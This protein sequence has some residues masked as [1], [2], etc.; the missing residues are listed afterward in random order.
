MLRNTNVCNGDPSKFHPLHIRELTASQEI[1]AESRQPN[2]PSSLVAKARN[3]NRATAGG[4]RESI[5][6]NAR[7]CPS[8]LGCSFLLHGI[9][10]LPEEQ[11]P[12]ARTEGGVCK[13]QTPIA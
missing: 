2:R 7:S 5:S 11:D 10:H 8:L 4:A 9:L 6:A 13:L 1:C 12:D 3:E